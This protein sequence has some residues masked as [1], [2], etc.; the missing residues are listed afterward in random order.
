[1]ILAFESGDL[2][3]AGRWM[4]TPATV[5]IFLGLALGAVS[6]TLDDLAETSIQS[7][8]DGRSESIAP[9]PFGF[10]PQMRY[11]TII[12][13]DP[14]LS[15]LNEQCTA[16]IANGSAGWVVLLSEDGTDHV[17]FAPDGS[18]TIKISR[19]GDDCPPRR[20]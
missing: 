11:A 14:K 16:V 20:P 2:D 6:T 3:K 1:M 15:F 8:V 4:T 10:G 7:L 13:S 9:L 5:L 18:V 19:G 17:Y 12:T